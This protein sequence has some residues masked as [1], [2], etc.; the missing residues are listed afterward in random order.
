MEKK[1]KEKIFSIRLKESLIEKIEI[2]AKQEERNRNQQ[3]AYL[4]KK[5]LEKCKEERKKA[6]EYDD[7]RYQLESARNITDQTDESAI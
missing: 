7:I 4:L 2:E 3:I 1:G 5:G 6:E